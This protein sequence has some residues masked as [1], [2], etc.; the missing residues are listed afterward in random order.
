MKQTLRHAALLLLS[1][2]SLTATSQTLFGFTRDY[3]A[4]MLKIDV[5]QAAA[6][7][8]MKSVNV[9]P[10]AGAFAGEQF[11]VMGMDDD[12]NTIVYTADTATGALTR[13]KNLGEDAALPVDMSYDY[14]DERMYFITNSARTEGMSALWTLDL[15]TYKMTKVQD[16]M[17]QAIRALAVDSRGEM[18]GMARSGTLYPI[19]KSTGKAGTAIGSTGHSPQL[20]TALGFDHTTGRLYWTCYDTSG[21]HLY[22]VNTATATATDLGPIGAG[23]GLI[24]VALDAP[25]TPSAATAPARVDSLTVTAAANGSLSATVAWRN[26]SLMANGETLTTL[27]RVE[28]LRGDALIATVTDA[29]PGQESK[30]EDTT[31]PANGTYRYTVRAY[32]EIGASAD[33]FTDAYIGHDVLAAPERV[34]A[35]LGATVGRPMQS[36]VIAW[37]AATAGAHGGY[38]VTDGVVYDV[39]R[40]NDG[41]VIAEGTSH[42]YCFDEALA[43]TLT[44]YVYSVTPRNA[45]GSGTS[46][47]SNYLVNGPAAKM[48][49]TADFDRWTDGQLWTV[50]DIN[51]DGY[52]FIWHR[53]LPMDGKGM[54]LYQTHEY[55]YALDMIVSPPLEFREGHTYR[56]TVSCCNSFAPYPESFKLYNLNGYTT[57]GAIPVGEPVENINHPHEFRP[58]TFELSAE[59]DGLG[60]ADETFVSF[61]GVCCTSNPSMQMFLVDRV[62]VEDTTPTAIRDLQSTDSRDTQAYTLDGRRANSATMA[63]GLYIIN[64]K[65]ILKR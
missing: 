7:V 1:F 46:R 54:Y 61:L 52:E 22:E 40:V 3:P 43:D 51:Q 27:T 17:G 65:K 24:T 12:F 63:P 9:L 44:R 59:D 35:A 13:L 56:I 34:V 45:D 19:D 48:P 2:T 23:S 60:T 36:N 6:T 50:L 38:T 53:Y 29:V 37:D 11:Y 39:V 16:N 20:F 4:A 32:N 47:E 15:T 57:Q 33:R 25:Y 42:E 18:Y 41:K 55:N 21:S 30:I 62:T 64:G 26:P 14:V 58:Y 8:R 49:F 28:V 10:T 5:T 31:V